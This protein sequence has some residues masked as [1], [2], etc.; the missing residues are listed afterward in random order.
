MINVLIELASKVIQRVLPQKLSDE[1]KQALEAKIKS[2]TY[3]L[4]I[5]EENQLR[6]F[7]LDYEGRARELPI[8]MQ[9]LRS[10]VRP[11]L[12]YAL[13]ITTIKLVWSGQEIPTTLHQLNLICLTFWFGERAVRNYL[14][15]KMGKDNG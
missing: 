4:L 13:V 5:K 2:T 10:S 14:K 8:A 9:I 1:E 12:T 3:E 6:N 7:I 15:T 11:V